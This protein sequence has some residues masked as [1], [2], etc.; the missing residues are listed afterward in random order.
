MP[1]ESVANLVSFKDATPLLDDPQALRAQADVDGYLFFKGLLDPTPIWSLRHQ[2]LEICAKHGFLEPGVPI[3]KAQARAGFCVVESSEDPVYQN[4]YCDIQKLRDFHALAHDPDLIRA[5]SIFFDDEVTPHPLVILRTI[6]PKATQH[7]T[8]AHQDFYHVRGSEETWTAWMPLGDCP[9]TLGSL[10]AWPGSHKRG[11]MPVVE[12]Q[13]A[14]L[15]KTILPEEP[16]WASADFECGDVLTFHSHTVHK[17][18][19]NMSE[20][21]VRLSMDCRAQARKDRVVAPVSVDNPHLHPVDWD[22]VYAGWDPQDKLR[23]YWKEYSLIIDREAPPAIGTPEN[24]H[25]K[26]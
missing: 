19:P 26:R 22:G 5:R 23:Y 1:A 24:P 9:R 10:V 11:L 17:G 14:G 13:G 2:I 18:L 16:T 3:E 15:V 21:S 7:T 20:S 25:P 6:F 12:S 8:G 4:Y